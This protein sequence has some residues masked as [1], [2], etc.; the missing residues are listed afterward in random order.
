MAAFETSLLLVKPDGVAKGLVD[1]IRPILRNRG[2]VIRE[3]VTK[4]LKPGT[5][6]ALYWDISDVRHRDYFPELVE[7]MSSKPVHIFVVYGFDAVKL[8][9]SIIGKRIPASG[10]RAQYAESI[11]KN[12]AHGP[13]T[14]ARAEREMNLILG[15]ETVRQVFVIGGMSESG[16][17][18]L[19]RYLDKYGIT[20]LKIVFFLKRAMEKMGVEGD[21]VE[22]N[23][24]NMRERPD[25]VFRTFADEFIE[26]TSEMGIEYCCLESLYTAGL[27]LH[28]KERMG[29]DKVRIV[30]VY[31]EE[32][33]RLQRQMVR[34]S[35][36]SLD[37]AKQLMLPRDQLKREWGVPAIAEVADV[38]IDNSGSIDK[39]Q[40]IADAMI[41]KYCPDVFA[42]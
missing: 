7:F 23:A 4:T 9:R 8:V 18:S 17:S 27:A 41:F 26:W 11:I 5:V 15:D 28:L 37:E 40:E 34:Q 36:T 35:L 21:F 16:K 6:K 30:Y 33:I 1:I 31:M 14:V 42:R 19:G 38:I 22:W 29:K 32:K 2:L 39:L 12:V 20:R 24:K 13:H 3:E 10:L 25:W